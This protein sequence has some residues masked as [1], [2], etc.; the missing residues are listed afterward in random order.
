MT[1]H[2]IVSADLAY[3]TYRDT[4]I[5]VLQAGTDRVDC[6]FVDA[7]AAGLNGPPAPELLAEFL[8]RLCDELGA[9]VLILDGPQGWKDPDNGLEHSR[10]CERALH[11]PAKTG[12]PGI[13]KPGNYLP[14]VVFAI[15]VFDA[16]DERGWPR[17]SG[18][19]GDGSK[20]AVESFPMSAWKS[21]GLPMLPAK[22]RSRPEDLTSRVEGLQRRFPLH[23]TSDP[24]HDELQALVSGLAGVGLLGSPLLGTAS[25]GVA[26]YKRDGVWREGII[27]NPAMPS[28]MSYPHIH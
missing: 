14:F 18:D 16:L 11:T 5:A 19:F 28:G 10:L 21:L 13:V 26:P 4:G 20:V 22:S 15:A 12:L 27:I 9:T 3:R 23:L 24:N 8:A 2:R 6:T 7:A 17:Y 1:T 25:A